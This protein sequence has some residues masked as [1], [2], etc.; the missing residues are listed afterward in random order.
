LRDLV[1]RYG[2]FRNAKDV[3]LVLP[4]TEQTQVFLKMSEEQKD[5]YQDLRTSYESIVT[6]HMTATDR[7]RALSILSRMGAVALHPELDEA[8]VVGYKANGDELRKWT[9]EN[10]SKVRDYASPK[11][12]EVVRRILAKPDCAHIVFVEPVAVHRWLLWC[13]R[14]AGYP[15]ER[16]A[17]LNADQA[18]KPLQRQ[19]IAEAFNGSPAIYDDNGQLVQ[20]AVPRRYDVVIANSVAYEGTD[21]QTHTCRVYHLDLPYEPATVQQRNGRADR[22][23]NL[24]SVLEIVWLLSEKSYDAIKLGM[25]AGKLRWMN[26]LL[27]GSMRETSNPAAGMDLSVEDMLLMLADDPDAARAAMAEIQRRNEAQRRQQ[28]A[29][30]GWNRLTSLV[31]FL[32]FARSREEEEEREAARLKA[33]ETV[34]FLY[35]IPSEIWPWHF[36][37]EKALAGL[38]LVV[39]PI[40]TTGH[41]G[42]D[43]YNYRAVFEGMQLKDANGR[44]ITFARAQSWPSLVC[45]ADGSH[46]WTRAEL[47]TEAIKQLLLQT[48]ILGYGERQ[49]GGE[50]DWRRSFR[51]ALADLPARGLGV[52]SLT[53]APDEW[54]SAVWEEFKPAIVAGLVARSAM[55]PI[56]SGNTV[57]LEPVTESA[58]DVIPPTN[59]GFAEFLARIGR[60]AH[61]YSSAQD[62]A[63]YWWSRSFP[64]GVA[65]ARPLAKLANESGSVSDYR[66]EGALQK[67][68]GVAEVAEDEFRIFSGS[69]L[70]GPVFPRRRDAARLA[71]R[72]LS[73]T[74]VGD[75]PRDSLDAVELGLLTWI[76]KQFVLPSLP[77]VVERA[78]A[79]YREAK[80]VGVSSGV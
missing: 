48:P 46:T 6:G 50:D 59:A 33:K 22:Q 61:E 3:G 13:L 49:G 8:P 67:G 26:D 12:T 78:Q 45:R 63:T 75:D 51:A 76:P 71:A 55:A 16:V 74:Q 17:I 70:L 80:L 72:W 31:N 9:W 40:T 57:V 18:P 20:E 14:D 42:A 65:D 30:R 28:V 79:K 15:I 56:R 1:Y 60:G 66:V 7:Y 27:T 23:G 37:V 43:E 54:T 4:K 77:E 25:I 29:G 35:A 21:L 53:E 41:G 19:E 69:K 44:Y 64:R 62:A 34:D 38:P 58:S 36:L 5:K 32:W 47:Q 11:L 52:L 10:A 24:Q 68:W 2:D 39:V 73:T